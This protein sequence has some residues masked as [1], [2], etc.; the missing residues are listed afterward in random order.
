MT[1]L[2]GLGYNSK[3]TPKEWLSKK[4][5]KMKLRIIRGV[6]ALLTIG[7][8]LA[9]SSAV[10]SNNYI[11]PWYANPVETN[12]EYDA[13][14]VLPSGEYA[15]Q[16][17]TAQTAVSGDAAL[18][19]K[20]VSVWRMSHTDYFRPRAYALCADG[21]LV[22]FTLTNDCT[23]A[24]WTTVLTAAE[25]AT[26]ANASGTA[27]DLQVTDDG[28]IAFLQYGGVWKAVANT[29]PVWELRIENASGELETDPDV[30]LSILNAGVSERG[31]AYITDGSRE[32]YCWRMNWTRIGIGQKDSSAQGNAWKSARTGEVLD[33]SYGY[34][35]LANESVRHDGTTIKKGEKYELY[36]YRL[37]Y[38]GEADSVQVPR[39]FLE[40]SRLNYFYHERGSWTGVEEVVL[41][42]AVAE[43]SSYF[44]KYP[45][46][47]Q[48][49]VVNMPN[50]VTFSGGWLINGGAPST[51]P[52]ALAQ[53]RFEEIN[54]SSLTNLGNYALN[55]VFASGRLDLPSMRRFEATNVQYNSPLGQNYNLTEVCL[56]A[57]SKVLEYVCDSLFYNDS[58]LRR[59]T[60]GGISGF[61]MKGSDIFKGATSLQ[62]VIFTGGAPTFDDVEYVF[63][64][65]AEKRLVFAVPRDSAEWHSI[66][67]GHVTLLKRVQQD[68]FHAAYPDRPIPHGV[69]DTS[70]F[71]THYPQY[72]AFYDK[73]KL[74]PDSGI[75][76]IF[77]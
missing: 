60:F 64:D 62:D 52:F 46:C 34:A 13:S 27:T 15:A 24:K 29:P 36:G 18:S 26:A 39:I 67:N 9:S 68:D 7:I 74:I 71:K 51:R 59:V 54:F 77:R 50:R 73:P 44:T 3:Q 47:V 43:S 35:H 42:N 4:G 58:S 38:L 22:A 30:A 25:L 20:S 76:I 1:F 23:S 53:S 17:A 19:G 66:L 70:V 41:D 31:T 49:L 40:S 37:N 55:G 8:A 61:A 72:V 48:R 69:V 11:V 65:T 75:T 10:A 16:L 21:D 45:E 5:T 14:L 6:G 12:V 28:R 33:F 57:E 2:V 32:L 56:S 63:P